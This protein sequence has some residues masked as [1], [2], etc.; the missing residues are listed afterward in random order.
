MNITLY[1]GHFLKE[2][3][4]KV[5]ENAATVT[6]AATEQVLNAVNNYAIYQVQ[7]YEEEFRQAKLNQI[8]KSLNCLLQPAS[9]LHAA[10]P[11]YSGRWSMWAALPWPGL[12]FHT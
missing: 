3:S 4:N 8:L 1:L 10:V 11:H 12:S 2:K 6:N 9:I 5:R 7:D